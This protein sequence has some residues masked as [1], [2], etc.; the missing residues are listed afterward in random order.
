MTT[1][2]DGK[3]TVM[4]LD[5]SEEYQFVEVV[6]PN[7]YSVN[8]TPAE[9]IWDVTTKQVDETVGDVTTTYTKTIATGTASMADTALA[10]L[11]ATGGIGTYIFTIAGIIIM[12]AAAGFFFVSR[13]KANR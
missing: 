4:G 13:R 2:S 6:A 1:G 5:N 3:V 11:P 10:A 8:E 9:I 7:G 12:A